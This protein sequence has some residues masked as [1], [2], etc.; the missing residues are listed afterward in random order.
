LRILA[1]D[2]NTEAKEG[3]MNS[4]RVMKKCFRNYKFKLKILVVLFLFSHSG[5]AAENIEFY[6]GIRYLGMGDSM[7]AVA[8]DE[9]AL[10]ANP[11]ALGRLRDTYGTIFDPELDGNKGASEIYRITAFTQPFRLGEVVPTVATVPNTYYSARGQIMPSFVARNF[12]I[13]L[14]LKYNLNAEANTAGTAVDTFYREDM[15]LLL[16]YNLRLF[17]GRIKIGVTGKVISRIE[18]DES[19]LDPTSDLDIP[20][21]GTAGTA[22]EGLGVGADAAI[23]LAGPWT[24]I[25][26]LTAVV[27][28][29]GGT[30]FDKSSGNRLA[31]S[32]QRP[33]QVS[34]DIDVGAAIFPIH[35]NTIRSSWSVEYRGLTSGATE[36][37]KGKLVHA[38]MEMNFGDV[39]FLRAG[40]NQRYIT[41]GLELASE[42]F[43]IQMA[44]YGEEIGS[45]TDYREDRRYVLKFSFRY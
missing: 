6:N 31:T 13:G 34:Q 20:T 2:K 36:V 19:A 37:D 30:K 10:A 16:G 14:L 18:V 45:G 15:A 27:R 1:A 11:A 33:N 9:T 5:M 21:M 17:D 35:T 32:T 26:T 43:Q 38:G 44:T 41:G 28:D 24:Y 39:F 42:S 22:K 25:P 7:I 23:I 4:G 3:L 29:V 8:N 12:G 40:Y